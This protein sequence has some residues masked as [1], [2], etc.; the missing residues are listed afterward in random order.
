VGDREDSPARVAAISAL[1]AKRMFDGDYAATIELVNE[2]LPAAERLGPAEDRVRLLNLRGNARG[3]RGDEGGFED[4]ERSIDLASEAHAY[5][6]LHSSLNNLMTRQVALG[7][8]DEARR[9][10]GRMLENHERHGT[11]HRR[12][13]VLNIEADLNYMEGN[14]QEASRLLEAFIAE[15]EA[16]AA[17]YLDP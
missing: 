8:L 12:G 1:A 16:S 2:V 10:F 9:S 7:R 14:W 3:S 5:E 13:W 17:H 15:S 6:Q 11:H 4:L